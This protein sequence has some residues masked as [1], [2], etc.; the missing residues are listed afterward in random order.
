MY[1]IQTL[2]SGMYLGGDAFTF[3]VFIFPLVRFY[4]SPFY[5]TSFRGG[6]EPLPSE[7]LASQGGDQQGSSILEPPDFSLPA[8]C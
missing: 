7:A 1:R 2:V 8:S 6:E 5:V 4:S 3:K